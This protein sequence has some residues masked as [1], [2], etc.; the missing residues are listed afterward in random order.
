MK[1]KRLFYM[2]WQH[3]DSVTFTSIPVYAPL[4]KLDSVTRQL[5][6]HII[7]NAIYAFTLKVR[8]PNYS[9]SL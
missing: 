1:Q 2:F 4:L 6:I 7:Q 9:G 8:G 5:D 3:P